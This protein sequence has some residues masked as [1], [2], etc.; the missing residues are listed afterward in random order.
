MSKKNKKILIISVIAAAIVSVI[1]GCAVYLLDYYPAEDYI[2]Q[3]LESSDYASVVNYG[4]GVIAFEPWEEP[5]AGLIFYPGGK[6]E[7]TSYAPLMQFLANK[8]VLCLLV[9]MPCNL[10]VF[11]KNA[12]FGLQERYPDIE[13]WYIGGHSLGGAMAASYVSEHSEE[14][15]GLIML[16]AYSTADLSG[17]ALNV[18]SIYGSEDGIMNMKKYEKCRSNLPENYSEYVIEDGN[19]ANFGGYGDQRG[20]GLSGIDTNTQ[21]YLTSVFISEK[22]TEFA[23]EE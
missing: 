9:K 19:H 7:Y 18:M 13:R 17:T 3:A 23:Q 15:E 16:G 5:V 12:A 20:D 11:G 2:E 6:V 10:A 4:D 8:G 21:S 1:A 14:F 22:I